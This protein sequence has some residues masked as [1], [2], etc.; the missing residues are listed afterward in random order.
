MVPAGPQKSGIPPTLRAMDLGISG[1]RA[2]VAAA[3]DGL[4]LGTRPGAGGRRRPRGDLRPQPGAPGGGGGRPRGDRRRRRP[5]PGRRRR[6]HGRAPRPSSPR[7]PDALGG[8]DILVPNAGGPPPGGF[9]VH[10]PGRLRPGPR[11]EP[12]L[13]RGHVHGRGAG[14]AGPGWGRVAAITSVSVRQPIPGLILSNT[15][16]AGVTGFLKT[17]ALEVAADGVTVELGAARL[18]RHRP[19]AVDAR[20][21]PHR[22]R[23]ARCPPASLGRPEDFGAVVAFLCSDQARFITGAAVPGR[24]RLATERSSSPQR[25]GG[26]RASTIVAARRLGRRRWWSRGPGR[27]WTGRPGRCRRRP[28]SA[29]RSRSLRSALSTRACVD[30]WCRP[31]PPPGGPAPRRRSATHTR[32]AGSPARVRE[33]ARQA[34]LDHAAALAARAGQPVVE[35]PVDRR[36]VLGVDPELGQRHARLRRHLAEDLAAGQALEPEGVGDEARARWWC[37][38]R[39]APRS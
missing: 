34:R 7:P 33:P 6:H 38:S 16:R 15:A 3:T 30:R 26:G 35:L 1:R 37:R 27:R 11:A 29:A 21:R 25:E 22:R 19:P 23:R 28:G 2:A 8:I 12:A 32:T 24:R 17:L 39:G 9:V 13:H 4:G 14:H 18:A 36:V 10:R 31:E 5:R 20:R